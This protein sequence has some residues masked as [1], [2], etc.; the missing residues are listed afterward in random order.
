M[1]GV[2]VECLNGRSHDSKR[3]QHGGHAKS[4]P[5]GTGRPFYWRVSLIKHLIAAG[6]GYSA[7]FAAFWS[8]SSTQR[9]WCSLA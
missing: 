1:G 3:K 8:S 4:R 9:L 7:G 5:E 2:A 6:V